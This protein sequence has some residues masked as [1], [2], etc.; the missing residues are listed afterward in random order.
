MTAWQPGMAVLKTRLER[1]DGEL[2]GA[3]DEV[4]GQWG[5]D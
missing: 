4:R 3:V 1:R 2:Y 5:T